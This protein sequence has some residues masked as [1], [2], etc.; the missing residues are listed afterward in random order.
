MRTQ[1]LTAPLLLFFAFWQLAVPSQAQELCRTLAGQFASIDGAVEV[2]RVDDESWKKAKR[3]TP[4]C[5]GDAIRV[6]ERSRAAVYLVNNAVL[7]IDQNT[8]MRLL[9]ISGKEQEQS[10][11]ELVKGVFQSFSRRPHVLK[12]NTPYLNGLIEGTEFVAEA[13][14]TRSSLTVLEGRVT[15][16]NQLGSVVVE[17][18]TAAVGEPN[19][20]PQLQI[21]VRPRD[22]MQ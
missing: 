5:V 7:R 1:W 19:K 9:N 2:Q 3:E 18:G 15:A 10:W 16:E 4:L 14:D 21:V 11:L 20:A 22:A 6:G 13:Q 17:P 8:T 12:V